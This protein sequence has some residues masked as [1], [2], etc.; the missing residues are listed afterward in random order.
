M[1]NIRITES[2]NRGKIFGIGSLT[3]SELPPLEW[4]GT[5]NCGFYLIDFS[6]QAIEGALQRTVNSIDEFVDSV[7]LQEQGVQI[8][9][10]RKVKDSVGSNGAIISRLEMFA[11]VKGAFLTREGF[12]IT[13]S[14]ISGRDADF[15]YTDPIIYLP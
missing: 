6:K 5:L 3:P 2:I 1:K 8:D 13:E 7:L 4:D 11:S 10:M 9:I 12:D 15:E 14:Q